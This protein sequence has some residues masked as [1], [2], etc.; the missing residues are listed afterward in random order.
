[1]NVN[2]QW[3]FFIGSSDFLNA[4]YWCFTQRLCFEPICCFSL[5]A[6]LLKAMCSIWSTQ[7]KYA[8][9]PVTTQHK[10]K[11]QGV[12]ESAQTPFVCMAFRFFVQI[13]IHARSFNLESDLWYSSLWLL[14][15][16]VTIWL[17]VIIWDTVDKPL[18]S[19]NNTVLK[20]FFKYCV[21]A[22]LQSWQQEITKKKSYS[23]LYE[24][25]YL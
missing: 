19:Q 10:G 5:I 1:M 22:K 24:W 17:I 7:W 3:I 12:W 20:T 6:V 11:A 2:Y 16:G 25:F 15:P 9:I 4:C 14:Y 23:I 8:L 18:P 13:Y 21:L